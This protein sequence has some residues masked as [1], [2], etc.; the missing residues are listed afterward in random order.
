M[1]EQN[2]NC[3]QCG[4]ELKW[5]SDERV[6][7]YCDKCGFEK[8]PTM[9][10][11]GLELKNMVC[12]QKLE[13]VTTGG[14]I[15]RII[16]GE[17]VHAVFPSTPTLGVIQHKQK[18]IDRMVHTLTRSA[19]HLIEAIK[20]K[21]HLSDPL[22]SI[23]PEFDKGAYFGYNQSISLIEDMFDLKEDKTETMTENYK[24]PVCDSPEHK[25][26]GTN[27]AKPA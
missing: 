1:K 16:E 14:R 23:T 19:E 15:R 13:I 26:C 9:S 2:N 7:E 20:W 5:W 8:M 11:L 6:H 25:W 18:H 10:K 21:K 27:P 24:C 17:L 3:P 22:S 4:K 12:N